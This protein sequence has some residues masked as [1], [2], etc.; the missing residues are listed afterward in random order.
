MA[1]NLEHR[2]RVP[3][4]AGSER[5]PAIV[6]VHGWLGNE[7]VMSIFERTLPPEAVVVSPRAP[8]PMDENSFG[9]YSRDEDPATFAA[10]LEVLRAFVRGVPAAY[11]VDPARVLLMGFS[12]GA[13]M[14]YALLLSDPALVTGVAQANA[15]SGKK[16][17]MPATPAISAGSLS[18]SA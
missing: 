1:L 15:G 10:G 16:P 8:L 6:M 18:R 17:A 7:N 2:A 5:R 9:W 14:C 13:A 3:E 12:Q 11:P 4:G